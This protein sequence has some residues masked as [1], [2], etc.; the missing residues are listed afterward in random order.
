MDI[1]FCTTAMTRPDVLKK[2]YLSF[3]QNIKGI[4]LE[5]LKLYI[6]IDPLPD[7]DAALS[8]IKTAKLFFG[9]VVANTPSEPNFTKAVDWCWTNANTDYIFHLEDDWV[10]NRPV[11]IQDMMSFFKNE[12]VK[13]V[14]LRAYGYR[15]KKMCLSPSIICKTLYKRFAGNFDYSLNP[16]VQLRKPDINKRTIVCIPKQIVLKDIG[17]K[18]LKHSKYKR[19]G[20]KAKFTKWVR[21]KNS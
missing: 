6:N 13:Q 20:M 9:E 18:W 15:Y 21:K 16:E 3:S 5:G 11:N 2:T 12:K 19:T 17:R 4:A 10:L 14:A 1:S 8:V 7:P